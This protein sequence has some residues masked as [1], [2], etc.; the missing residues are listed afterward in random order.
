MGVLSSTNSGGLIPPFPPVDT[1][2]YEK[3]VCD[4]IHKHADKNINQLI[5]LIN[6]TVVLKWLTL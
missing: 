5:Q 2:L 3:N 1:P 4:K 6:Q